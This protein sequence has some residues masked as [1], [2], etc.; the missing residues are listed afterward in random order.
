[1][2]QISR[3]LGARNKALLLGVMTVFALG[4]CMNDHSGGGGGYI[5]HPYM[6]DG[7][8]TDGKLYY[9]I[10][11][12]AASVVGTDGGASE[13]VIPDAI[14]INEVTYSLSRVKN[15]GIFKNPDDYGMY[16][17]TANT[18]L[19]SLQLGPNVTTIQAVVQKDIFY[20]VAEVTPTKEDVYLPSLALSAPL[21]R[22]YPLQTI[23]VRGGNPAYDAR[24]GSNCLI[25]FAS[26]RVVVAGTDAKVPPAIKEIAPCAFVGC[27]SLD[28]NCKLPDGLVD[29][30]Y[31]AFQQCALTNVT[32]PS[33]LQVIGNGAFFGNHLKEI[34]IPA[35]VY[36]IGFYAFA[37]N[38]LTSINVDKDNEFFDSRKDCNAIIDTESNLLLQGCDNTVIPDEVTAISP[39]AFY[40]CTRLKTISL[41][42][43]LVSIGDHAFMGC[44]SLETVAIP[45]E[46]GSVGKAAFYG[47]KSLTQVELPQG[48]TIGAGAFRN[49]D[50]LAQQGSYVKVAFD[51]PSAVDPSVFAFS[52]NKKAYQL[53][54]PE[55]ALERFYD[56]DWSKYFMSITSY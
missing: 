32:L 1:M 55:D 27:T 17:V 8:Y 31:S 28:R 7:Y 13:V 56:S 46:T 20:E 33:S 19:S 5:S 35:D 37:D 36:E 42:T 14:E 18:G 23:V 34:T 47:C 54:V 21:T 11:Q 53:Q 2:L 29:I 26:G 16:G 44:I 52:D 30:G 25:H 22:R 43:S 10:E 40:N 15:L 9:D 50:G 51:N 49:C 39:C 38:D 6:K 3:K 48:V 41:P 24:E 4:S 45:E 12:T